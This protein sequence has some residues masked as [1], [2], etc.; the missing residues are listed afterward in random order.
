[1]YIKGLPYNLYTDYYLPEFQQNSSLIFSKQGVLN[2]VITALMEKL[3]AKVNGN[4]ENINEG[5]V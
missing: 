5:Y 1:M 4:Y 3:F 2:T